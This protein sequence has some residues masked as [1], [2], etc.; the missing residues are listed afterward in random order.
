MTSYQDGCLKTQTVITVEMLAWK[1]RGL[2]GPT[3]QRTMGKWEMLRA[4]EMIFP[5]EEDPDWLANTKLSA[6]GLHTY[7]IMDE[8]YR[9]NMLCLCI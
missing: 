8:L 4:G 7:Y 6:L 9:L 2:W 1:Q 5:R 3:R